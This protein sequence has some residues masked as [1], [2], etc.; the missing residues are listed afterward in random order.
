MGA[1]GSSLYANDTTCD[2]RDMYMSLLEGQLQ[3]N[4][5]AYE[6]ILEKC[7]DYIE[8]PHEAPLFWFALADTQW[9]VGRLMPEV[10]A[11]AI[12]WINKEG[13]IEL[14]EESQGGS[15]GWKKTLKKLR[16]KLEAEQPKEKRFRKK[17]IPHQNP[18][19]LNDVYAYKI[20]KEYGPKERY[21][22]YGK[23]ILLQKIEETRSVSSSDM[24]MRIQ[25]Y[26]RLFDS[27]PSPD[28]VSETINDYRLLPLS[29]PYEQAERYKK[30]LQGEPD[31]FF[32]D[33]ML[34]RY[35]PVKMSASMEQYDKDLSYPKDALSYICTVEGVL[36]IQH[37]R[38]DGNAN[39]SLMWHNF[40]KDIGWLFSLWKGID[41]DIVGNGTFEYPTF[42]QRIRMQAEAP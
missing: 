19:G 20:H 39:A 11:K 5:D 1:W 14:W 28:E 10:K 41:Y 13:G 32:A 3:S 30:R 6:N 40:H 29:N 21:T 12:E 17:N 4:Q 27:M 35:D 26:D 24:V 7:S 25:V 23:Y 22:V 42:E 2:V 31:P 16:V 34:C 9:K 36:N 18:W 38:T 33:E 8:D 15:S 37:E